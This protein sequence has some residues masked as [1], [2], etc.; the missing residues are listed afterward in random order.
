MKDY[1]NEVV[2]IVESLGFNT[3]HHSKVS[4]F[5]DKLGP[6]AQV[7]EFPV[8]IHQPNDDMTVRL[9]WIDTSIHFD[10]ITLS[11]ISDLGPKA[12]KKCV[13]TQFVLEV[14]KYS[15]YYMEFLHLVNLEGAM[16]SK[17]R[18]RY[19]YVG[20]TPGAVDAY[21]LT[22][23]RNGFSASVEHDGQAVYLYTDKVLSSINYSRA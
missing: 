20:K 10:G 5:L 7:R 17:E 16:K 23:R 9:A 4:N 15:A 21:A 22:L 13:V 18:Q 8:E 14:T 11:I 3:L 19:L 6:L 12:F 2:A 1:T